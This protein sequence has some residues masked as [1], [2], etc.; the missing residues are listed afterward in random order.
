MPE[1]AHDDSGELM[2]RWRLIL[3]PAADSGGGEGADPNALAAPGDVDDAERNPGEE[4]RGASRS[5]ALT[6]QDAERDRLLDALY[7]RE[8]AL[9]ERE[10]SPQARR[11]GHRSSGLDAPVWIQRVRELFP[12]ST[13]EYL[14][15]EG[16]ERYG[17]AQLLTDPEVLARAT[18]DMHMVRLL[19]R[20]RGWLPPPCLPLA[21]RLIRQVIAELEQRL[22]RSLPARFAPKRLRGVHGGPRR[23]SELDW[24]RTLR[25]NL[26]H[27]DPEADALVLRQLYFHARQRRHLPWELVLLVD[28]SGSMLDSVIHAAV[29]ASVLCG[30]STLKTR[31]VLFD[32]RIVDLGDALQDPVETLLGVQLGGGTD[33]A[34][35][36]VYAGKQLQQPSRS[37]VVLISDFYE[38]GDEDDLLREVARMAACGVRLL[39]LAALDREAKPEYDHR[40]SR[41]L[42]EAGMPV[43]AMTPDRLA[44][45]I[46]RQMA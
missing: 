17:L 42:V 44:D 15:R 11:A 43:A 24:P 21:R 6:P 40:M 9:R 12:A 25:R 45:W 20:C 14:Q 1:L 4:A 35:A 38:G 8:Y 18:P 3:G 5:V 26:R 29:L 39:G 7:G 34:A 33:I 30:L 36:M 31:L 28:Q 22:A 13:A 37:L 32:T 46:A 27:Y 2:R 23:L 16:L 19:M 10:I 41:A